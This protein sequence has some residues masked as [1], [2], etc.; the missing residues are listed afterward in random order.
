[1]PYTSLSRVFRPTAQSSDLSPKG[2]PCTAGD[3]FVQ[4]VPLPVAPLHSVA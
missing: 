1:M 3:R 4:V 2:E